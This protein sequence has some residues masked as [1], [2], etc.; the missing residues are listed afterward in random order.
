MVPGAPVRCYCQNGICRESDNGGTECECFENFVQ[1]CDVQKDAAS[2]D[3][4]DDESVESADPEESGENETV[5]SM[6]RNIN[7]MKFIS[8]H[9]I[10]YFFDYS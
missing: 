5:L 3:F 7:L 9:L 1:N 6:L 2:R 4:V 8:S 10:R